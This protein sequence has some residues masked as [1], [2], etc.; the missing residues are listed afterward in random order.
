MSNSDFDNSYAEVRKWW[1]EVDESGTPQRELGFNAQG[2]VIVAGPLGNN[3]GFWTDSTMKF[4][5]AEYRGVSEEAFAA[6]WSQFQA[7]WE[8]NRAADTSAT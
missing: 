6:V 7:E 1:V 8:A 5:V 2:K 3:F 4:A